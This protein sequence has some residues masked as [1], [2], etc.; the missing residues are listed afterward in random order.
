M[1]ESVA[2]ESVF[3]IFSEIYGGDV[4]FLALMYLCNNGAAS[5]REIARYVGIS[6]KNLSLHLDY[7]ASKGAVEVVY[8]KP[9]LKLYRAS[10]KLS[11]L[12]NLFK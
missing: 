11:S 1:S 10:A 8:S 12:E 3:K 7:L 5:I 2:A 4:K 9:N 6:H